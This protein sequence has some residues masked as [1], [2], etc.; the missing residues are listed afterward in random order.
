MFS[1]STAWT[2]VLCALAMSC[3]SPAQ[4]DF[5]AEQSD[6][7]AYSARFAPISPVLSDDATGFLYV[8][9]DLVTEAALSDL[10]ASLLSGITSTLEQSGTK[11]ALVIPAPRVTTFEG[12][13]TL[14][15][16]HIQR[17]EQSYYLLVNQLQGIGIVTPNILEWTQTR[18]DDKDLYNLPQDNHWSPLG[19]MDSAL[20]LREQLEKTSF[21]NLKNFGEA[22]EIRGTES[23][24]HEGS[25]ARALEDVCGVQP[26]TV[27]L[28]RPSIKPV[29]VL[30]DASESLFGDIE[31][32]FEVGLIGTSFSNGGNRDNFS[33]AD[34]V[35][36]ALQTDVENHAIGGGGVETAFLSFALARS[37]DEY[38]DLLIW[39][40]PWVYRNGDWSDRLRMI[41][42]AIFG[43]CTQ[44]AMARSV[45]TTIDPAAQWTTLFDGLALQDMISFEIPGLE[46]GHVSFEVAYSDG[47]EVEINVKRSDR[48]LGALDY[49]EWTVYL[50]DPELPVFEGNPVSVSIRIPNQKSPVPITATVCSSQF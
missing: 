9:G 38:P 49:P 34:A 7:A 22:F 17:V 48:I 46:I 26:I 33:W 24:T 28:D 31:T 4:A 29:A 2:R 50:A 11:L 25:F 27:T 40:I 41:R 10:E 44:G 15:Q 30:S 12:L 19:A 32:D 6:P 1:N 47:R 21:F 35:R 5:C 16:S 36:F 42:G 43:S 14:D 8:K 13:S 20:S 23:F 3:G 45:D 18:S 39:E 37:I